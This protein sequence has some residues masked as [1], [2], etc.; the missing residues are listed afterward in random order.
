MI[1]WILPLLLHI[2]LFAGFLDVN[3][4]FKPT[5]S[6]NQNL[7]HIEIEM[8]EHIH[9][10]KSALKFTIEPPEKIALG[11]YQL[12]SAEKDEFGDEFVNGSK[13]DRAKLGSLVFSNVEAK[14]K[15][16]D[17]FEKLEGPLGIMDCYFDSDCIQIGACNIRVPIQR[18]NENMRDMFSKMSLREVTL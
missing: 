11:A 9:L 1:R 2:G 13:V 5:V 18:I 3:E 15:L 7:I 10:T 4:A 17:F 8:A 12:P 16:E 6:I 14:K